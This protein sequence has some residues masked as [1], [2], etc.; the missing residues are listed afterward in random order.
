VRSLA[1][2]LIIALPGLFLQ[3]MLTRSHA[4]YVA[5]LAHLES[6]CNQKLYRRLRRQAA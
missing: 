2:G 5:F 4:R 6:V 3:Y 1:A